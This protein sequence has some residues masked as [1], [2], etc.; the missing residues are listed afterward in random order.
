MKGAVRSCPPYNVKK[1]KKGNNMT[2]STTKSV[3]H[4]EIMYMSTPYLGLFECFVLSHA[5]IVYQKLT[6]ALKL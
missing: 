3:Y 2:L 1:K 5:H 4:D 6:L